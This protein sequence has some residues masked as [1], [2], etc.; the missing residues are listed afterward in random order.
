MH[1]EAERTARFAEIRFAAGGDFH[2]CAEAVAVAFRAFEI[3]RKPV[4]AGL[5]PVV[6]QERP[7]A[8]RGHDDVHAAVVVVIRHGAAAGTDLGGEIRAA[9]GRR[10]CECAV[11]AIFQ[12]QTFPADEVMRVAVGDED[13]K[14]ATVVKVEEATAPADELRG[15]RA[16]ARR[17]HAVVINPVGRAHV[18]RAIAQARHENVFQAVT[19]AI[20]DGGG[21][22]TGGFTHR[23]EGHASLQRHVLEMALAVVEQQQVRRAVVGNVKVRRAVA[24]VVEHGH[25]HRPVSGNFVWIHIERIG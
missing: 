25:G 4:V 11:T 20:A 15:Q 13:V 21:H 22:G 1:E 6:Q 8:H 24:V 18:K 3:E 19:V 23:V 12:K 2:F 5:V 9:L 16:E 7:V 17:H 10:V 14:L